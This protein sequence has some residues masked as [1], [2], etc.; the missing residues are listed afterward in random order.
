[1]ITPDEQTGRVS[2]KMSVCSTATELG[3][4]VGCMT[5]QSRRRCFSSPLRFHAPDP[6]MDGL[7]VI[8]QSSNGSRPAPHCRGRSSNPAEAPRGTAKVP[9]SRWAL[10][11]LFLDFP[12]ACVSHVLNAEPPT[13]KQPK[14]PCRCLSDTVGPYMDRYV[15]A[16]LRH[17]PVLLFPGTLQGDLVPIPSPPPP[18]CCFRSR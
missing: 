18:P 3:V 6:R 12:L 16:R 8:P 14:C 15:M 17:Y 1:M 5:K 7:D 11:S 10:A 2:P 9:R 13:P 4:S